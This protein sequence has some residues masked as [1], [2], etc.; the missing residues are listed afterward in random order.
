MLKK[1]F[2]LMERHAP[3]GLSAEFCYAEPSTVKEEVPPLLYHMGTHGAKNT[4]Q[5]ETHLGACVTLKWNKF[6][7][8]IQSAST[9]FTNTLEMHSFSH[10]TIYSFILPPS[11]KDHR[12][13][14]HLFEKWA[15]GLEKENSPDVALNSLRINN[16]LEQENLI[17]LLPT[18][19]K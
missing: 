3:T 11:L 13:L 19:T 6:Q 8:N 12:I 2:C 4:I 17:Q 15:S 5:E 9:S 7:K 16:L 1:G 10:S 14:W 18:L